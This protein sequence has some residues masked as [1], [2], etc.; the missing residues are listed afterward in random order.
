MRY[1]ITLK[2]DEVWF[3]SGVLVVSWPHLGMVETLPPWDTF[4]RVL[5]WD[6]GYLNAMRL[7]YEV[8]L[9]DLGYAFNWVGS[10]HSTNA[11]T[12]RFPAFDAF[13]VHGTTGLFL[14][15]LERGEYLVNVSRAWDLVGL[16]ECVLWLF[17]PAVRGR[18]WCFG[19][20]FNSMRLLRSQAGV[21]A[22]NGVV[23]RCNR[24]KVIASVSIR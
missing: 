21:E 14:P 5:H 12:R 22:R 11:K 1:G 9:V 8:P 23:R 4:E 19:L 3:N 17:I 18:D 6:Q 24:R 16:H 2:Q 7:K 15:H 13:F 10:F 20:F